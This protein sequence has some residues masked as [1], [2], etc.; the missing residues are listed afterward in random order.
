M[1]RIKVILTGATGMVGE[2]VLHRC[3][4]EPVVESV[5]VVNRRSCE[6]THSKLTEIIHT[7]FFDLSS[8]ERYLGGYDACFFCLGVSSVGMKEAEYTKMTHTL[9][10]HFGETLSRLNPSMVFEYVS[11]AG[12]DATE[13][14]STM[15]ARVKG[16][17]ENDLRKLP[18]NKVYGIRP[19]FIRPIAG[20]RR[21][22]PF[23]KYITWLFPL[24]RLLY[25]KGFC[26]LHELAHA[27]IYAAANGYEKDTIE[28]PDILAISKRSL[29]LG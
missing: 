15:W 14:G 1:K 21:T 12:T 19:G 11:G 9:T 7:D 4:L 22:L 20:M 18:F 28:G 10:L 17:T 27:M 13:Q 25:A 8:I 26:T 2:G 3:L 5:L 6:V 24:G 23:Y 29:P 16:K